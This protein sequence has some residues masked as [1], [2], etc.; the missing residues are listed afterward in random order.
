MTDSRLPNLADFAEAEHCVLED[1]TVQHPALPSH[2]AGDARSEARE[3]VER[4]RIRDRLRGR[5]TSVKIYSNGW[6]HIRMERRGR[7]PI[8]HQ[9]NLQFLDAVPEIRG[10]YPW[11]V[12]R[13]TGMLAA[14]TVL[15]G[16]PAY[17][18]LLSLFTVPLFGVSLLATLVAGSVAFY[19]SHE[20]I[21]FLTLHGR[22]NAIRFGAG[23]GTIR[24]F[25]KFI[26]KLVEAIADAAESVH[27]ETVVYLRA[28]M[29]E[30][31]RL[32]S[33]GVVSE[34]ECAV[35]TGKILSEF[36]GPL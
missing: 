34:Q 3:I 35:S 22:A 25:R 5:Q 20:K 18:G 4:V 26:P 7:K 8:S 33:D 16:T 1:V 29:R 28:E 27:D 15:F 9:I 2:M 21:H 32:R 23:L 13:A 24:R 14:A 6:A 19:L 30:H 12:L 17:F 31:Y 10:V 36:D 11:R